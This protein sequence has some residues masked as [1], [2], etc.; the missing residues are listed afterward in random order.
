M[1][2]AIL[3]RRT[4]LYLVGVMGKT[5]QSTV[6]S[7]STRGWLSTTSSWSGPDTATPPA[8]GELSQGRE[9]SCQGRDPCAVYSVAYARLH[10]V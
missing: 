5:E 8:I 1:I 9:V 3:D 6:R 2:T 10:L 4:D 7:P